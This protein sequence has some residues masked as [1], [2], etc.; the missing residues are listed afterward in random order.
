MITT[1]I[2]VAFY[3]IVGYDVLLGGDP[4]IEYMKAYARMYRPIGSRP[5]PISEP[6]LVEQMADSELSEKEK[7]EA[8][9][10]YAPEK[11]GGYDDSEFLA[12][13]RRVEQQRIEGQ[14]MLAERQAQAENKNN[15]QSNAKG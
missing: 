3:S 15:E 11:T 10:L 12:L 6:T 8:L 2:P 4:N 14:K 1:V 13:V 5:R 9:R 7:Q